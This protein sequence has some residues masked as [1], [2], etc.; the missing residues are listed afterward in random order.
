V[1]IPSMK[2]AKE[3]TAADLMAQLQSDP[4]FLSRQE[5]QERLR[6]QRGARNSALV[7][8]ILEELHSIGVKAAAL[9]DLLH[10][11]APISAQ[12]TEL[13]L[14]YLPVISEEVLQEQI[15]RILGASREHFNWAVLVKLFES[16]R[17]QNLRWVIANTMAEA[18]PLGITDW[19]INAVRNPIQQKRAAHRGWKKK[20]IDR[21]IT[22]VRKR[23]KISDATQ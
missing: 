15:V 4:E 23:L 3:I 1:K 20:E 13:L 9:D 21:A 11:H 19:V 17:S 8:P 18:R 14:R 12:V 22:K 5:E 16:S 2:K 10:L 7:A 6:K